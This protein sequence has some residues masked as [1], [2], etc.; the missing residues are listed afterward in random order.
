[1]HCQVLNSCDESAT[2]NVI[3]AILPVIIPEK[4]QTVLVGS[5][6]TLE[7]I[8]EHVGSPPFVLQRWQKYGHRLVTDGTKYT[9][10][11]IGNRMFLTI[12]NSTTEDEGYYECIIENL[13]FEIK[14]ASVYLSFNHTR[15]TQ[16]GA[17]FVVNTYLLQKHF[18]CK[19][20]W[21]S[22][23]ESYLEANA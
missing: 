14:Q 5:N 18:R 10:Q 8:I 9:S 1:M 19:K 21:P 6:A 22:K 2:A 13:A 23:V 11:L 3:V 12:L 15:R 20:L 16:T 7:C 4:N 17:S